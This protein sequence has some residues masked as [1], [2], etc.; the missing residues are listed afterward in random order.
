MS[1]GWSV[2]LNGISV[3]GGDDAPSGTTE[4]ACMD[5]A[6]DGMGVPPLRTEDVEFPQVD[7]VTHFYDWYQP[8]IVTVANAT[9]CADGCQTCPSHREKMAQLLGAWSRHCDD[10]E[11]VI[12]TDCHDPD[13]DD[14]TRVFTGPY[15]VVGRP[16]VATNRWIPGTK[17]GVATLRFDGVDH[18]LYILDGDGTPGSGEVCVDLSPT[19]NAMCRTYPRCYDTCS[20]SASGGGMSY[21]ESVSASG[22]GPVNV[23]NYGTLCAPITVTLTGP[24]S[25]PEVEN[26]T[27]GQTFT[28]E[29]FIAGGKSVVVNT[30]TGTAVDSDGIDRDGLLSGDTTWQLEPGVNTIRLLSFGPGDTGNAEVCFR[31]AVLSG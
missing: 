28:Y 14:A 23:N 15:G 9:V 22:T 3:I 21:T 17:C 27:T 19:V 26:L 1:V 2:A 10:T 11:L 25:S 12:F 29:G 18:R 4:V 31:P 16:R 30:V 8:R 6:P 5:S 13:A 20:V 7:G 24:L